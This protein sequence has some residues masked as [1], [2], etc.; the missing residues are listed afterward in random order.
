MLGHLQ[1]LKK[2]GNR[3]STIRPQTP[4]EPL[5]FKIMN[6]EKRMVT[7]AKFPLLPKLK[8][9]LSGPR[10]NTGALYNNWRQIQI[11]FI[12]SYT[13]FPKKIWRS[14]SMSAGSSPKVGWKWKW[15]NGVGKKSEMSIIWCISFTKNSMKQLKQPT[16]MIS[17]WFSVEMVQNRPIVD[18]LSH[19]VPRRWPKPTSGKEDLVDTRDGHWPCGYIWRCASMRISALFDI[20]RIRSAIL[21]DNAEVYSDIRIRMAI[22]SGHP[23]ERAERRK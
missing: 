18:A 13:L 23:S 9:S 4:G 5:K 7:S 3:N 2:L 15:S 12:H 14:V 1:N 16:S 19:L 8:P 20:C 22:P 10:R 11:K 17:H 6:K 21:S